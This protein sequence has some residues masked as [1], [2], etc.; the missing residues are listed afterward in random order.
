LDIVEWTTPSETKKKNKQ[1]GEAGKVEAPAPTTTERIDRTLSG[2]A[3]D[4]RAR[5]RSGGSGC[6]IIT[7]NKKEETTGTTKES[8]VTSRNLKKKR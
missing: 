7:A 3:R 8:D 2:A 5:G 6:R 1:R 4:E